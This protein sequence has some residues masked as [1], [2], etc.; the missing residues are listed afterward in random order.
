M[1]YI[2]KYINVVTLA[3][4]FLT[5]FLL[6]INNLLALPN[7][8]DSCK[9]EPMKIIWYPITDIIIYI[10]SSI[11]IAILS[12]KALL[13]INSNRICS[14][15][16]EQNEVNKMMII[17]NSYFLISSFI[18]IIYLN[19][20]KSDYYVMSSTPLIFVLIFSILSLVL[21]ILGNKKKD[22]EK[23]TTIF[24]VCGALCIL[25]A[26]IYWLTINNPS[27]F[28]IFVIILEFIWMILSFFSTFVFE[29][30][31]LKINKENTSSV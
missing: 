25:I 1:N 30:E 8:I 19:I 14:V 15:K 26:N 12:M 5:F 24:N 20:L 13:N 17:N 16:A 7:F 27:G 6:F 11:L 2:K 3:F 10:L 18:A 31:K 22:N 23:M 9:G 28:G 21:Y 4:A 29:L